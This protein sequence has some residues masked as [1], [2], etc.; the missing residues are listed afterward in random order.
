[1]HVNHSN[2]SMGDIIYVVKKRAQEKGTY[3]NKIKLLAKYICLL[4]D[5]DAYGFVSD[6]PLF[7]FELF[8]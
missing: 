3:F 8:S 2:D 4:S 6:F 1:M 5:C 7:I